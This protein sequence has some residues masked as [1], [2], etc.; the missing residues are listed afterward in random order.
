MRE[1]KN[2]FVYQRMTAQEFQEALDALG[3][4][5]NTFAGMFGAEPRRV[6]QY[7]DPDSGHLIPMWVPVALHV[8]LAV[9]GA[10]PEARNEI[11]RRI[12]ADK[13]H[14]RWERLHG[15]N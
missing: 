3:W 10:L 1:T 4:V 7:L 12:V 2:R 8:L 6:L 5:P 13:K 14:E 11:D 15:S 9:P